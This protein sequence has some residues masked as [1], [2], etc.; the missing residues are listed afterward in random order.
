MFKSELARTE[1]KAAEAEK[2]KVKMRGRGG[3][4]DRKGKQ[5][6]IPEGKPPSPSKVFAEEKWLR[7][8]EEAGGGDSINI[9]GFAV[10]SGDAEG[11]KAAAESPVDDDG[12]SDSGIVRGGG[13]ETERAAVGGEGSAAAIPVR[14]ASE[15]MRLSAVSAETGLLWHAKEKGSVGGT[16]TSAVHTEEKQLQNA[17]MAVEEAEAADTTLSTQA[18]NVQLKAIIESL[19]QAQVQAD[20]GISALSAEAETAKAAVRTELKATASSTEAQ[21]DQ[22]GGRVRVAYGAGSLMSWASSF[23]RAFS[24]AWQQLRT[25]EVENDAANKSEKVFYLFRTLTRTS[26]LISIPSRP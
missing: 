7:S 6:Q 11:G 15:G 25:G 8:A 18:E 9:G 26:I 3:M 22:Q 20:A 13:A 12:S 1:A 24:T 16:S 2:T 10:G 17:A 5:L 19:L 4:G 21:G 23:V 14:A